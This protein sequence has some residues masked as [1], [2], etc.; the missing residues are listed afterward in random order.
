MAFPKA[1]E[2]YTSYLKSLQTQAKQCLELAKK[3]RSKGMDPSTDVEIQF[4][5]DMADRVE[6]LIGPPG[7]SKKIREL[8]AKGLSREEVAFEIAKQIVTGKIFSGSEEQRLEQAVRT[9]V[10]IMTEGVLVAPTE[11]ISKVRI[12]TN[13]D[14]TKYV[15]V[16]YTGPIR[17]AGG[18]IAALSVAIA[19]YARR[20]IGLGNFRPTESEIERYVEEINLYEARASH[21]QY[22][23]PDDDIRWIIKNCPV[24]I[25]GEPTEDVEVQVHR[26][27]ERME[28]NRVRGGVALV[29][30]EGIA[31]KSAKLQKYSKKFDLRWH[32]LDRIIKVK[33]SDGGKKEVR[34]KPDSTYLSGVVAGRPIFAHPSRPGGFRLV[35]GKSRTNSIM[36]KNIHPA[37]MYLLDNFIAVGT[38]VKIERPGKGA[39]ITGCDTIHG[40][41]VRLK[42]K[43]VV[44]IKS[45]EEAHKLKDQIDKILFLG[46]MLVA[47]GDFLKTNHPLLP[48]GWCKAWW[49]E[50]CKEKNAPT[51]IKDVDEA[52][53]H[54]RKYGVPLHPRYTFFWHDITYDQLKYLHG[55]IKNISYGQEDA[56]FGWDDQLKEILELLGVE[57]KV[58]DQKI[59]LT[60]ENAKALEKT[61]GFEKL[62][63]EENALEAINKSVDFVVKAKAPTYIG[64]R[65][66]RPEK[67]MERKMNDVHVLFPTGQPKERSLM[68]L[69]KNSIHKNHQPRIYV[70]VA[71]FRCPKCGR[72]LH[73]PYCMECGVRTKLLKVCQVCGSIVPDNVKDHCGKPTL[74]YARVPLNIQKLFNE[75]KERFSFYPEDLRGVKGMINSKKIP[76]RLEKGWFRA[77]HGVFVFK[78]GTSRFDATDVPITHFK[79]REIHVTVEQLRKMG[80]TMDYTGAPLESEDQIVQLKAQDVI[81]SKRALHYFYKVASFIDD[82]LIHLYS[83]PAFYNLQKP[84]DVIGH[85]FI[86]LSPHTSGAV[87]CRAIGWADV[88]CGFAHPY[89]HTAKRRNCD[90][91]ED[92]LILLLDALINFSKFYL[93]DGRGGTMDAPITI[94][95]ALCPKEVDD[96]VLNIEIV[97]RYP[98]EFYRKAEQFSP[99]S[100][101]KIPIV[102]HVLDT[103]K[104]FSCFTFTHDTTD[105][106][107]GPKRTTY[108]VLKSI[109]EKVSHQIG[110][111]KR[112]RAVDLKDSVRRLIISHF[113]PDT[114]GNLRSFSRQV[115]RCTS[116][117]NKY[118]RVPLAGKCEKCGGNL[119][120]T[121][122]KGG[123]EKYLDISIDLAERYGLET[124]L[125][126]RLKM[127]KR[128]IKEIFEDAKCRQMGLD[129]FF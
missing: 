47:Y 27:L 108:V 87:L 70:E 7:I 99:P 10:A 129:E 67:A 106:A 113:I 62:T 112:I 65:M 15:A 17:S 59:I 13:P 104:Q 128:E 56:S 63:E 76:E 121:I 103:E 68:K 16:Y 97:D 71:R 32:W 122:H 116:C 83:E 127:V 33:A 37:T 96:E 12:C 14:Q 20:Q 6:G 126:Q 1:D 46:D 107:E 75:L 86:G 84:E 52:F 119:T 69:Y 81:L 42:N 41:I 79:P 74:N 111:Q 94:T 110:L 105:F 38:H 4:A 35:Y 22:K 120:L 29:T 49:E 100:H 123:I 57:H 9:G 30:C 93:S 78:D 101:V 31:L 117:N 125:T 34:I 2:E 98:L 82:I 89:F 19:D 92:A 53:E 88:A 3:V 45:V 18:T 91:D 11:G 102:E 8:E 50:E 36:A 118:R 44:E 28:T 23:P 95:T 25:H 115:F 109:P 77:K 55:K 58:R 54:A 26:D 124:Y 39:V 60:K 43:D 90:G 80:Y 66:G 24:C 85:L 73:Y 61:L 51:E 72:T 48:A 114:Y 64:A 21:L 5:D 40:P